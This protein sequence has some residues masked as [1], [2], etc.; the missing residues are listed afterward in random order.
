[1]KSH[2]SIYY[3]CYTNDQ[4]QTF[5]VKRFINPTE[6]TKEE[7]TKYYKLIYQFEHQ[8]Q[9]DELDSK[10][11]FLETIFSRFNS[12]DNPL[13][14]KDYQNK[15]K[16]LKAH[17]SMSMGDVVQIDSSYYMVAGMGFEPVNF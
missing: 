16:D 3:P 7:F 11:E 12:D 17:T 4:P 2:I 5:L 14:T 6:I 8:F 15:I 13:S 1:M 10:H 9:P